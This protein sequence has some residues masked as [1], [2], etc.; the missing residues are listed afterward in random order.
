MEERDELRETETKTERERQTTVWVRI[1]VKLCVWVPILLLLLHSFPLL[2]GQ[3]LA[4][5]CLTISVLGLHRIRTGWSGRCIIRSG[6][7]LNSWPYKCTKLFIL[8]IS[9]LELGSY[10]I[11][12][13]SGY[14]LSGYADMRDNVPCVQEEIK[15]G[16]D[17]ISGTP[18]KIDSCS[19]QFLILVFRPIWQE[20]LFIL[21]IQ[22]FE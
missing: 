13:Q 8:T 11:T 21:I 6:N 22:Y 1:P 20:K 2:L 17:R 3:G 15:I 18:L 4:H 12:R 19:E 14:Q 9:V 7:A 5:H 10:R 16:I